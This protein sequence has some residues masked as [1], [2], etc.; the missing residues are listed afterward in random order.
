MQDKQITH[1]YKN[2]PQAFSL[3]E[4]STIAEIK[5]L[6]LTTQ[7]L[8]PESMEQLILT[9]PASYRQVAFQAIA[10]QFANA[11]TLHILQL[12]AIY[13]Q[14]AGKE[15][16]SSEDQE[17][18]LGDID[19]DIYEIMNL[20]QRLHINSVEDLFKLGKITANIMKLSHF[21][22]AEETED[23]LY[24]IPGL[25][26]GRLEREHLFEEEQLE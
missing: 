14:Q 20:D 5:E 4:R 3:R 7:D 25:Y 8:S 10:K 9:L 26:Q 19:A 18:T 2:P 21:N 22:C 23:S 15:G 24:S 12:V 11:M 16:I 13:R 6:W 17:E 1:T